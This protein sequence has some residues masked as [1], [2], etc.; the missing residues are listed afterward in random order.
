MQAAA[1]LY[2]AAGGSESSEPNR[3]P[4]ILEQQENGED[5]KATATPRSDGDGE[6]NKA[7]A[8]PPSD[9][10]ISEHPPRRRNR[11]ISQRIDDKV[12]GGVSIALCYRLVR[13]T[14][15]CVCRLPRCCMRR[16]EEVNHRNQT[17]LQ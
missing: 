7:T 13:L 12:K 6:D 5:N 11:M 3:A 4:M 8:T 2:A 9:A 1:M 17:V 14:C 15:H 16:Q 10:N